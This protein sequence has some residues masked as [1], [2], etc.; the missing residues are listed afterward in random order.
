MGTLLQALPLNVG[1]AR[2]S[3]AAESSDTNRIPRNTGLNLDKVVVTATKPK[4]TPSCKEQ[5]FTEVLMG[6]CMYAEARNPG[7]ERKTNF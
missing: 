3:Y 6:K 5:P 2:K 4:K 7:V 1:N